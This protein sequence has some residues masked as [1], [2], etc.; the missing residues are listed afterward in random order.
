GK[1]RVRGYLSRGI[2]ASSSDLSYRMRVGP[3]QIA[4]E[5][6]NAFQTL[7]RR[8]TEVL[9]GRDVAGVGRDAGKRVEREDFNMSFAGFLRRVQDGAKTVAGAG[10]A[11]FG[12]HGRKQALAQ[13]SLL[14][15][16]GAAV[17]RRR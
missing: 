14:S 17:P 6:R 12:V 9:R 15:T 2:G 1:V 10:N 11:I 4:D 16:A 8:C 3:V 13:R 7:I 5:V